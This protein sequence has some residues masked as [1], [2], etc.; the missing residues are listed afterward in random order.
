MNPVNTSPAPGNQQTLPE[1]QRGL[2]RALAVAIIFSLVIPGI[3]TGL[4]LILLNLQQSIESDAHTRTEK[5]ADLLQAGLE[6]PL[7]DMAPN[8]AEPLIAA[9]AA[10]P[11]VIAIEVS[12]PTRTTVLWHSKPSAGNAAPIIVSRTITHQGEL[13]GEVTLRY[14]TQAAMDE[15]WRASWR[16]VAVIAIQLLASLVLLGLWLSRRALRPLRSLRHAAERIASGDMQ[17]PVATLGRDEFGEL[18]NRLDDMRRA[19]AESVNHLEEQVDERTCALKAVNARLQATLDELQRMQNHLVQAEKLASLG[20]LVAGVAHELNTPI[21]TG[22]TVVSTIVDKCNELHRQINAG[23]R[24]SQ[25]D[26]MLDDIAQAA[27]LAQGSLQRAAR[28]VHDFKQVAVDQTS[29]RRRDFELRDTL[30]EMMAAVRLRHKHAPVRFEIDIPP[31]IVLDSYPGTLE[32]V[33]GN[34]IDN[35]VVHGGEGRPSC[36]IV[37]AGETAAAGVRISVA[38]DGNGIEAQHL[39]RVFDPFF[40]TR[41]GKGGSGLG[42]SIAYNLVTAVLGGQI[43]VES[44]VGKGTRFTIELPLTAPPP[45]NDPE[46]PARP[47]TMPENPDSPPH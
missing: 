13:L 43:Q 22:V 3:A 40:T 20:S 18:A 31:G 11:S 46:S 4:I 10:D 24:R 12:D 8:T 33:L 41:L 42:L 1:K 47:D 27:T 28:L 19:L 7:W 44:S 26:A 2:R 34:L 17:T 36:R 38:D 29:A 32:Q 6:L 21:G 30:N 45:R 35:A 25:L 15:A 16:L 14:S 23:I 37:V 5:L 39:A 9:I